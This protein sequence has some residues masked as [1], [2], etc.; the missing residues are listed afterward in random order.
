[1]VDPAPGT[2]AESDETNNTASKTVTVR[3]NKVRNGSFESA[4]NGSS[5]DAWSSS[6][7]TSYGSGGTDGERSVTVG[8]GG[9]WTS[10]PVPVTA[11]SS[12]TF[13]IDATGAAATVLVEQLSAT[14]AVLATT[15][16]ASWELPTF[17]AVTATLT[18]VGAA[19]AVRVKLVGG[20]GTTTF[21]D[22][23][24]WED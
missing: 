17:A 6:G 12:Y 16:R 15:T 24:L 4:A 1:M 8:V 10:E 11:G 19:T 22:V 23:W 3:G 9:S 2:V 7:S 21:D 20:L 5:P 18:P 14:G 13:S